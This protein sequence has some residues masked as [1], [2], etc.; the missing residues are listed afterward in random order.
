MSSVALPLTHAE[1]TTTS[2]MPSFLEELLADQQD[3]TAVERF[4]QFHSGSSQ[5]QQARYYSSLLPASP[6]GPGEQYAFEVD[7]DR[8]SGCKACVTACHSLNGLDEDET[9]RDVGLLHITVLIQRA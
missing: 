3:L 6:P 2:S 5:P 4:S 7:L 9:W 1:R 8:C